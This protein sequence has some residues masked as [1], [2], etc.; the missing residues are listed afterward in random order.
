VRSWV[1]IDETRLVENYR[2][3]RDAAGVG[4]DVL[5]V[6]KADAYG[7]DLEQCA[8]ALAR[9]GALWLGVADAAEG[10]QA[11]RALQTAGIARD[12][13]EVLVMCGVLRDEAAAVAEHRLTPV[14][15]TREQVAWLAEAV[16]ARTPTMRVHVEV[17][18]GMGRQGVRPGAELGQLLHAIQSSDVLELDGIC[19]H[20]SSAEVAG[21]LRTRDQRQQFQAA[22]A[23]VRAAGLKPRWIHAGSSSTVDVSEDAAWL[24]AQAGASGAQAMVRCGLALYGYALEPSNAEGHEAASHIRAK[25]KPMM[26]WK[27]RILDVRDVAAGETIGYSATFTAKHAMRVALLPVGYADG[28]RRELSGS[29]ERAGG[30]VVVRGADGSDKRAPIVGRISMNLTTVDVTAIAG[31]HVGDEAVLLGDGVTADDHARIAGTIPYE[32]LCGV[33]TP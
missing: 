28:L 10:V 26:T 9:A 16:G 7:H 21:S 15:W 30:W 11:K 2:L 6:V 31:V 13:V 27:T 19:T 33:R 18:T 32:I 1:E 4:T 20:F 3:V 29:D 14:L 12:A 8:V 24:E 25:L 5:A 17:E 23:Q 22:I